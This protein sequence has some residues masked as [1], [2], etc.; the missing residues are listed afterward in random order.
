MPRIPHSIKENDRILPVGKY[1]QESMWDRMGLCVECKLTENRN[2]PVMGAVL[3]LAFMQM[4][5][6]DLFRSLR[7]KYD[8]V[9]GRR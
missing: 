8:F 9:V 7:I 2:W 5:I 1:G 3:S 6:I 4:V